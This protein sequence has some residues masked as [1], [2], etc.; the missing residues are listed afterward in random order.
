MAPEYPRPALD[1]PAMKA[2]LM[3]PPRLR[4]VK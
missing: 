1:I 2:R 4:A 3:S